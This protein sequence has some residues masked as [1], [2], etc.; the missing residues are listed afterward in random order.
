MW[1]A[2]RIAGALTLLATAG[3]AGA[4]AVV[5]P[6]G[7]NPPVIVVYPGGSFTSGDGTAASRAAAAANR[8]QA[9]QAAAAARA[10]AAEAR[11]AALAAAAAA[12]GH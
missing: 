7:T 12:R 1:T 11:A 4:Q 5:P 10:Q 8:A 6:V 3:A 9:Q 2:F